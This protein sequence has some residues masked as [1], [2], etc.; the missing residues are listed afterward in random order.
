MLPGAPNE[1][2]IRFHGRSSFSMIANALQNR[3][4]GG[5]KECLNPVLL[6]MIIESIAV[7]FPAFP[8]NC[9][10][11]SSEVTRGGMIIDPGAN[12]EVIITTLKQMDIKALLIVVTHRHVDHFGALRVVKTETGA[13]FAAFDT[14]NIG[15]WT[16]ALLL[17]FLSFWLPPDRLLKDGDTI[18]IDGLHFSVLHT[19]GHSPD[20]ISL[21]GHGAVFTCILRKGRIGKTDIPGGDYKQLMSSIN[22]KLLTLPDDTVVYPDHGSQTTIGQERK[23]NPFIR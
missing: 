2:D 5:A 3:L 18:D 11:V 17:P 9:Y 6:V 22:N 13:E 12:P 14:T 10:I 4:T 1:Y 20:G 16:G 8:T 7:G 15:G 19:P 21:F 23:N